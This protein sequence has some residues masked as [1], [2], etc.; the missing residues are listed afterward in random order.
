MAS[1]V[2]N[3]FGQHRPSS[4]FE[5]FYPVSTGN[6]LCRA[7]RLRCLRLSFCLGTVSLALPVDS[8]MLLVSECHA[9][10]VFC[11]L[12]LFFCKF[13][14]WPW[15][16]CRGRCEAWIRLICPRPPSFMVASC[17]LTSRRLTHLW[18]LSTSRDEFC[19][20]THDTLVAFVGEATVY[21]LPRCVRGAR[22]VSAL[23]PRDDSI[24]RVH[25]NWWWH[26]LHPSRLVHRC[27]L[28]LVATGLVLTLALCSHLGLL[29][30]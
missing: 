1:H 12:Q 22:F 5:V 2:E 4:F 8:P 26:Q 11:Y 13:C 14:C 19:R 20:V 3:P 7:R 18:R 29:I 30:V 17:V 6:F 9:C 27:L 25:R 28:S 21:G 16:S 10:A 24:N 15:R 23:A